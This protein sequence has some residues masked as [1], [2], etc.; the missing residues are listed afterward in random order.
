MSTL[1]VPAPGSNGSGVS[2]SAM[3]AQMAELMGQIA[4]QNTAMAELAA[5]PPVVVQQAPGVAAPV[6][7]KVA[8]QPVNVAVWKPGQAIKMTGTPSA[9][10]ASSSGKPCGSKSPNGL[11]QKCN[12]PFHPVLHYSMEA[13]L[14]LD[15]SADPI[16]HENWKTAKFLGIS[17][18]GD[19]WGNVVL[20]GF[21][22]D[23]INLRPKNAVAM[24]VAM[25]G[26]KSTVAT[27]IRGVLNAN[28]GGHLLA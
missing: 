26:D 27:H 2:L 12:G 20:V 9:K 14:R 13:V 24:A 7:A 17:V 18:D 15:G 21:G 4:A 3:Q 10:V 16:T 6:I 19:Y 11:C 23:C 8:A 1:S 22:K 25:G 28:A 5:R